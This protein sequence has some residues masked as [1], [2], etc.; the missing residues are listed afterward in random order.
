MPTQHHTSQN[1]ADF[2]GNFTCFTEP[3]LSSKSDSF[4]V[5]TDTHL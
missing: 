4:G 5:S 1:W 2:K 3:K